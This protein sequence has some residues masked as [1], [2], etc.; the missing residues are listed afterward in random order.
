MKVLIIKNIAT[1]TE[2]FNHN[3]IRWALQISLPIIDANRISVRIGVNQG[4][5]SHSLEATSKG[6][7][8]RKRLK[9]AAKR[10]YGPIKS[11]NKPYRRSATGSSH[12]LSCED[13]PLVLAQIQ[14]AFGFALH[15]RQTPLHEA[16][17]LDSQLQ[18]TQK[19]L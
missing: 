18:A 2:R 10:L 16:P 1:R 12:A 11:L 14:H 6:A 17:D 5:P 15:P 8:G 7:L 9:P 3:S 13:L 19:I 4:R